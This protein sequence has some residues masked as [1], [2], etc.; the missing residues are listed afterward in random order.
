MKLWLEFHWE[1][2]PEIDSAFQWY[3]RQRSGLGSEFLDA[4]ET[5]MAEIADHPTRY[6]FV[7]RDVREFGVTRFPHWIY[8]R[9]L[10]DRIRILSVHHPSRD[11]ENWQSRT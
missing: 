11:P 9:V 6:G 8:Y 10:P 1:V 7:E 4:I 3:E 2:Q 5:A